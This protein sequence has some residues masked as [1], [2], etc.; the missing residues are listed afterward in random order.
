MWE[1]AAHVGPAAGLHSLD[2]PAGA[3]VVHQC[4]PSSRALVLGS[5]QP[6][7]M[8]DAARA[9]AAGYSVARRRSGGGVVA[10]AA[11]EVVWVDIVIAPDDPFW[12]D[13][14][15]RAGMWVG[16]AWCRA[17]Q[18]L[19]VTAGLAV[20]PGAP[21]RRELGRVVCFDGLGAGE[22]TAADTTGRPHK[23]VGL[24]QRRGRWGAR[25]QTIVHRHWRPE[26]W[27]GCLAE[28]PPGLGEALESVT[29]LSAVLG[30]SFLPTADEVTGALAQALSQ[31]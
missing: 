12:D 18:S 20:H 8:V 24:S 5:T 31:R 2:L 7:A 4:I 6:D 25:F 16:D 21:L 11:D 23:L 26:D 17:L 19:G 30:G 14:V 10:V 22:V 28:C 3:G 1:V 29:D 13:D 27:A 15:G 9:A